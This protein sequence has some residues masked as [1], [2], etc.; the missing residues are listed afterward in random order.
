MTRHAPI[1]VRTYCDES[2]AG[3]AHGVRHMRGPSLPVGGVVPV[4]LRRDIKRTA[5]GTVTTSD[6]T[7]IFYVDWGPRDAQPLVFHHGWPLS[8]ID[9]DSQLLYFLSKG[10]RVIAH[11]RRGHGRS[12]QPA[13][14][15]EM[16]TYAADVA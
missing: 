1:R 16:D 5:M 13:F 11:D 14:G 15:H 7:D 10:Y 3:E 4:R 6:G 8:H 2:G 9:W 12:E